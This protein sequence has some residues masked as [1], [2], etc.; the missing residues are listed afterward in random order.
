MVETEPGH[1]RYEFPPASASST[2]ELTGGDDWIDPLT[3][4]RVDRPSLAETK[5]RVREP[6][7]TYSGFREVEDPRQHL[8]F[9][10][11]T[12]VELT[13][14]GSEPLSDARLKIQSGEYAAAQASRRQDVRHQLDPARGHDAGGLAQLEPRP[15]WTRGRRSCRSACCG[16]ASRG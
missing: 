4:E 3:L 2:F 1:F 12:E 6:G 15:G 14:V 5:V 11:D 16:T 10:P 13:L 8:V 9:L 7:A